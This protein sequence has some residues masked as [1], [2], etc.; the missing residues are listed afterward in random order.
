[1]NTCSRQASILVIAAIALAAAWVQTAAWAQTAT[2]P[3]APPPPRVQ[4]AGNV[5]YL[6]GGAGEEARVEMATQRAAFALRIVFS[7]PGGAYTVADHVDVSRGG[8]RVLA[9][10]KAGPILMVKLAPG[11]YAVAA[12]FGGRVERRQV[13]VASGGTQ[14]DWRVPDEP[15]R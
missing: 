7:L 12:S 5:E 9:V 15:K 14:L 10:D 8:A 4:R 11:D 2:D 3:G 1:M 13:K 6:S